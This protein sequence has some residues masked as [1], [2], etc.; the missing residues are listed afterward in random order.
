MLLVY[1][2]SAKSRCKPNLEN[3]TKYN[4]SLHLGGKNSGVPS[5]RIQVIL[6]SSSRPPGF[7]LYMGR[8]ERRVQGLDYDKLRS[9]TFQRRK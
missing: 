8:E 4:F 7:S 9:A 1:Y 5:M 6:D 3:T 2:C